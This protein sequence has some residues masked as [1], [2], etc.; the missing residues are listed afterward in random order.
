VEE[1]PHAVTHLFRDAVVGQGAR[2]TNGSSV[3]VQK[4]N[5]IRAYSQMLFEYGRRLRTQVSTDVVD[6]HIR[7]PLA[8]QV[9]CS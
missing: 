6:Y 2:R 4:G 1:L 5:T 7:E 3:R 8:R 9:G